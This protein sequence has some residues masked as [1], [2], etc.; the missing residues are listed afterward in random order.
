MALRTYSIEQT[1]VSSL[2]LTMTT[3]DR[4]LLRWF[5]LRF[6]SVGELTKTPSTA[7]GQNTTTN[8]LFLLIKYTQY[9]TVQHTHPVEVSVRVLWHVV[10]EDN[11]DP[12]NVDSPA[13]EVSGAQDALAEGLEGLV[14]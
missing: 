7:Q 4:Q 2:L 1:E 5:D 11:V 8:C 13:K 3:Q 10:V 14:L 6:L 9:S 12:L